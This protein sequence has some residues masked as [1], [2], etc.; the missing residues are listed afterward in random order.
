[1]VDGA[2]RYDA[3]VTI[4]R[5]HGEYLGGEPN[6]NDSDREARD[7]SRRDYEKNIRESKV[8][9]GHDLWDRV[10]ARWD[11]TQQAACWSHL[12]SSRGES[13]SI[14]SIGKRGL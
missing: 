10:R 4:Q 13:A 1:M 2:E 3:K 11:E 14:M 12:K 6:K 5:G 7:R 9:G 8:V